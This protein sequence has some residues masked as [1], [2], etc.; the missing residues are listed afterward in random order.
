VKLNATVY[1]PHDQKEKLPVIFELTPY[2]SDSYH[3]RARPILRNT[4]TC[5]PLS[6]YEG[7]EILRESSIRFIRNR[8]TGMTLWNGWR[9]SL[10]AMAR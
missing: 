7:A 5:L 2:I 3:E 8:R 6:T 4:D 9:R 1:R 10:G